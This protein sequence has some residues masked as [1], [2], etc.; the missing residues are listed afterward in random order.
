M[1]SLQAAIRGENCDFEEE[2]EEFGYEFVTYEGSRH[3]VIGA[4]EERDTLHR[5]AVLVQQFLKAF[6]PNDWW[7]IEFANNTTRRVVGAYGGGAYFVTAAGI[8]HIWSSDWLR[9]QIKAFE[10][11]R[12]RASDATVKMANRPPSVE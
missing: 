1:T 12:R 3:L 10:K 6:R 7:A 9:R 2:E 4:E 8:K 5:A 11:V